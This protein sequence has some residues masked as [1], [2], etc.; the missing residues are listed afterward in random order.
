MIG[1]DVHKL[2]PPQLPPSP[3]RPRLFR[4]VPRGLASGG[5][6][7]E[8]NPLGSGQGRDRPQIHRVGGT[9]RG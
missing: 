2:P 4:P 1:H 9:P 5:A 3:R 8:R 7:V 6:K